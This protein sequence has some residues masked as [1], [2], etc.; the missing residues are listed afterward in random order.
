MSS[1][2]EKLKKGMNIEETFEE[3]EKEEEE[4]EEEIIETKKEP[5]KKE[6]KKKSQTKTKEKEEKDLPII[7]KIETEDIEIKEK[8]PA[9]EEKDEKEKEETFTSKSTEKG[10]IK[11]RILS[12]GRKKEG[13]E[14][15]EKKEEWS[16]FG[17]E[18]EGQLAIDVYQTEKDLVIQSAIAGVKPE[19]LDISVERDIIIIRGNREK[20]SREKGDYLNQECFWGSFSREIIMPVET[21]PQRAAAQMKNGVLTIRIPKILREG[22]KKI[23]VK[24]Q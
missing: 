16:S 5:V 6:R 18:E 11:K 10:K 20:P 2:L 3:E 24:E 15:E 21:D 19:N 1:F 14:E 22:K 23:D 13:G 9:I 7:E 12:I 4:E 17:K 8:I